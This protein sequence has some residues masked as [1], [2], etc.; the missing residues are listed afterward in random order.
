[1]S[2]SSK[3]KLVEELR[4]LVDSDNIENISITYKASGGPPEER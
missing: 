1:M 4:E 2:D 3:A